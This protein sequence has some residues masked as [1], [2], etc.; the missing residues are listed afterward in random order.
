MNIVTLVT[1]RLGIF[2]YHLYIGRQ[3]NQTTVI[4]NL[5]EPKC[6]QDGI[7]DQIETDQEN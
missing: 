4:T 3:T 1:M 6:S 7:R 5:V 2:L